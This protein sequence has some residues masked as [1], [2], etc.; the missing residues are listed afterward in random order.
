[1]AKAE[2]KMPRCNK[3]LH[4]GVCGIKLTVLKNGWNCFDDFA[5]E[6]LYIKLPQ[7]EQK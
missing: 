3:C 4:R 7:G 5:D 6:D 2:T 1:M